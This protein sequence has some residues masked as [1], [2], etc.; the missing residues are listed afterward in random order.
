MTKFLVYA[1]ALAGAASSI[2]WYEP[3]K[4]QMQGAMAGVMIGAVVC[5]GLMMAL[6]A[7]ARSRGR[8]R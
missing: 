4:L 3:G 8:S 2:F 5:G 6:I 7:F 1:A